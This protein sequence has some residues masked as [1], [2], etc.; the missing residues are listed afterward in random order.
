MYPIKW[1]R[2]VFTCAFIAASDFFCALFCDTQKIHLPPGQLLRPLVR[3]RVER[4]LAQ[5]DRLV[6]LGR[7]DHEHLFV[8]AADYRRVRACGVLNR[9]GM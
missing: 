4:L 7:P 6:A 1:H 9:L 8:V 5:P 2:Q 3:D